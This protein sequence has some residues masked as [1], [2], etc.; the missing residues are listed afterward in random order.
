MN[1]LKHLVRA[2]LLCEPVADID[3]GAQCWYLP[4]VYLRPAT[5]ASLLDSPANVT[6]D[7]EKADAWAKENL[8]EYN[9]TEPGYPPYAT[10]AHFRVLTNMTADEICREYFEEG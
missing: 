5:L 1:K 9:I 3:R 4:A 6:T 8:P 10:A 7:V 2:W